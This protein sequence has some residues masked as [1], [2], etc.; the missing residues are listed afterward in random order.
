M[1]KTI[2]SVL[3]LL[4]G[5]QVWAQ[6][7]SLSLKGA[8]IETFVQAIQ[9]KTEFTFVYGQ[10]VVFN[11]AIDID[12]KNAK[13]EVVLDKV[14]TPHNIS[15][16]INGKHITLRKNKEAEKAL[17]WGQKSATSHTI[18]GYIKDKA[19]KETLIGATAFSANGRKGTVTNSYGFYSL[20]L[21]EGTDHIRFSYIG[22]EPQTL[23]IDLEND[24]IIIVEMLADNEIEEVVVEADRP[25]TG[26][27]SSRMGTTTMPVEMIKRQPALLGEPDVLKALQTLP[28]VQRGMVGTSGIHVRG[29]DSDQNLYLLDGVPLY[30]ID[31]ILGFMSAFTPDAVKHVDFYKASFPSRY[32]G[33]LSSVIDVRTKDG[34]MQKWH[35]MGQIGTL[36]SHMSVE[37]PLRTDKT[38]FILSARRSY[39]DLLAAPL[40]KREQEIDRF[41]LN[42]YDI[43]AKINH[44]FSDKDRLYA[45]F[46]MGRD[47]LGIEYDET[48]NYGGTSSRENFYLDLRWGNTLGCLRWNH[49][50]TPQLFSNVTFAYN[51]F[52]FGIKIENSSEDL[53]EGEVNYYDDKGNLIK[54]HRKI[55]NRDEFKSKYNS[56][57]DDLTAIM[58]F[59][60]H[61]IPHHHVKFGGQYIMHTFRPSINV[62]STLTASSDTTVTDKFKNNEDET[63]GNE[64][65]LYAEDDMSIGDKW[66]LNGGLHA[67]I[68][69]VDG[70]VYSNVEPRLST[71]YIITRGLRAKA[72]YT[73]MHQ[74]VHLL[75]TAPLSLP[76]DLWVPIDK[77]IKPMFSQQFSLGLSSNYLPTWE[78]TAEVYYKEMRHILD[79]KDGAGFSGKTQGWQELVSEGKGYSR[80][81][82]L[83]A[84]KTVGKTTGSASYTLSKTDRKF[85]VEVSGGQRFPYKF[86]RRNVM[87]I[88]IMHKFGERIDV[89]ASWNY[90]S[91]SWE[92]V[93]KQM[94]T[95]ITP[96]PNNYYYSQSNYLNQDDSEYR[97]TYEG[98]YYDR[99]NNYRL[100][101]SHQLDLS[102]NINKKLKHSTRTLNISVINAYNRKNQDI[103]YAERKNIYKEVKTIDPDT[104]YITDG[105]EW[106]GKK[107]VLKQLSIIPI[108]PSISYTIR[109]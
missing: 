99:R 64:F 90:M 94:T 98:D 69:A 109:F 89:A 34:D 48:D 92:T 58:D 103:V 95:Y 68:F 28:G 91:G 30:N 20:T 11:N 108:I 41:L 81:L 37:G 35:G 50:F 97:L 83:M 16:K 21:P 15:Y 46:Y 84:R 105:S 3:L 54:E 61:P 76:S 59:D 56:G 29:G 106:I 93:A 19:S 33:R 43:N 80:G 12:V 44:I 36:S 101:P 55:T 45:S 22:Y 31:H 79:Y 67:T 32:G 57:I 27:S 17:P 9:Q 65:D 13:L 82:E 102:V 96:A 38:S 107:T 51:R 25:E 26:T 40:I 6:E 66:Q 100:K 104:G 86:D 7:I 10:D 1:K 2:A 72:S 8:T 49:V 5:L 52:N 87:N 62:V 18:S 24:T 85:G 70:K 71:A 88:T 14:L 23:S 39:F 77:K 73:T 42:F 74:Y 47:V 53:W 60:Y 75:Q 78:F 63:I 4:L